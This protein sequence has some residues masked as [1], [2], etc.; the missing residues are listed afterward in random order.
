M[1]RCRSRTLRRLH[2]QVL[3]AGSCCAL[4]AQAVA[5]AQPR[6][7]P[8]AQPARPPARKAE[9]V[10]EHL[11]S[12]KWELGGLVAL[13][14]YAG[15]R[16]WKWGTAHFR[17]HPE[18]WFGMDTGSGGQDKL[19][20]AYTSYLQTEFL[21]LRLRAYH[22]EQAA[23]T[24]YPAIFTW[25]IMLYVEF[26]DAFSVDHGFSPEDLIMDTVGVSGAFARESFPSVGRVVDYRLEYFPS[27][28]E[29]GFHPMLDYSGQKFLLAF[30]P[31][32]L[33]PLR[34]TA[35]RATELYVGYYTRG[36]EAESASEQRRARVFL[37]LGVD[38][39]GILELSFGRSRAE[40]GSLYDHLGTALSVF[41]FPY[42]YPDLTIE[43]RRA[44]N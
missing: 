8:G 23:V 6:P 38:L 19:G 27:S 16:D 32:E 34:S 36:F 11:D 17:Y 44:P 4:S 35:F 12:L 41:Q 29:R 26:F 31:G 40:P 33:K 30:R 14:T 20:H 13:L 1:G 3:I 42:S 15:V 21:Y 37:G 2:C 9:G 43:Q 39:Q 22:G 10:V 25:V 7:A 24:A 5:Q 18:G 28:R